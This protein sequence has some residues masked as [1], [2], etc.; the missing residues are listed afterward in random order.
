V[1]YNLPTRLS[2]R[3]GA[4]STRLFVTGENLW[5]WS[6]LYRYADNIDVENATAPSDRQFVTNPNTLNASNA[7]TDNSGDGYN[8]PMLRS[9]NIG[10]TVTF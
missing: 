3:L 5:T 8:Y 2:A 4:Q 9:F 7:F 1:G 6:P 10:L